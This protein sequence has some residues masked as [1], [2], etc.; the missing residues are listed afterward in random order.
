MRSAIG[1]MAK[2]PVVGQVK[3]RLC[4]PMSPGQALA[5]A[6][7][8][9]RDAAEQA[10]ATG[11]DVWC[12]HTGHPSLV[13][14]HLPPETSLLRQRGDGLAERLAA[15]QHDL[16]AAGY[17]RVLLVGGDC[18]TVD[19]SYLMGALEAL[20][21]HAVVLGPAA[22]GGYTLIASTKPTPALFAVTMSTTGV[23]EDT[24]ARAEAEGL[25]IHLLEARGDLDTVEDLLLALRSGWLAAAPRTAAVATGLADGRSPEPEPR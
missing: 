7:A 23:L 6:V 19:T 24:V 15:A 16:H 25:G 21:D 22:D 13:A 3:T 14:P 10:D 1:L 17:D 8:M 11:A 4:P 5:A 20:S 12:V 9:L 18:P 2:A